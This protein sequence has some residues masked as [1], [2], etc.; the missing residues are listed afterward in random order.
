MSIERGINALAFM[1]RKSIYTILLCLIMVIKH[2]QNIFFDDVYENHIKKIV[3]VWSNFS[4]FATGGI[5][6]KL[7]YRKSNLYYKKIQNTM[8][9]RLYSILCILCQNFR[10]GIFYEKI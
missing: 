6:L 7:P 3:K 2:R 4:K 1:P 5:R 10:K 9:L 8:L